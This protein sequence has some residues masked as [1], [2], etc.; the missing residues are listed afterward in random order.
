MFDI[1]QIMNMILP[2]L[3][4]VMLVFI[5]KTVMGSLTTAL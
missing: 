1:S 5:L 2:L 3:N 4:V